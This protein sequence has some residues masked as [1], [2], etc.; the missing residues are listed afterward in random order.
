M[1]F[2]LNRIL[3]I[4]A[5]LATS[6]AMAQ[7]KP[8]CG[9]NNGKAASGEPIALGAVVGKTGP[10]DFSASALASQAYFKCVNAN[11]GINGRP[12]ELTIVDDQW[13][14]EVAAQAAAK[15]VK[16]RKVLAMV[17]SSSFVECGVNAKLYAQENVMVI[18]GV[19]VPRECFFAKNY[20]PVNAGPRVS[21]TVVAMYAAQQ[22]KARKMVCVI[23]NIPSLGNWACDGAKDWGK[24]NGVEV[25]VIAIDPGS[26]DAT[27]TMLQAAAKKP[28]AIILNVP[29]GILV[30]MLAAAEQQGLAKKMHFVSSTPA[31]NFD[32]P[33]TIGSA[34]NG[35]FDIH[36][37]FMPVESAG[38][39]NLNWKATMEAYGAKS[40]PRDSFAQA[41][42]LAARI[43]TEALLK[44]DPK[45]ID[46]ASVSTAL[47]N[48]KGF[49]SDILCRPFYVGDGA[50]H[51]ANSSGPISQVSG[52]GF[53]QVSNGCLTAADPELNDLREQEKKLGL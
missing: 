37:E 39:D 24:A 34:W 2:P 51:N 35:N 4:T 8:V 20:V 17:G 33:K 41:G 31:Y 40:D 50:R 27:S 49:K 52:N 23:P 11:G 42:Y 13:N 46:R 15:L 26:P 14:P 18:A 22:Y 3:A 1:K 9:L 47:R 45:K 48:V 32:V 44:M 29:K 36:L 6:A 43:A 25:D 12:V 16:D 19:G 7:G 53:K 5:L 28:D 30:P 21:A 38:V 10:D